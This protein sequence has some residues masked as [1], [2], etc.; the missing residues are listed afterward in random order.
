[1]QLERSAHHD[2]WRLGL[3]PNDVFEFD[4][5]IGGAIGVFMAKSIFDF[6]F[7]AGDERE[8]VVSWRGVD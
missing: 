1:M 2:K 4:L 7:C 3:R 5:S 8:W 6:G